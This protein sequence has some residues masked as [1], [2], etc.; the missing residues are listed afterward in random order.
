MPTEEEKA[1]A[2]ERYNGVMKYIIRRY[3]TNEQRKS[4]DTSITEDDIQEVAI[5]SYIKLNL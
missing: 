2:I 3:I 4:E 1:A 5:I